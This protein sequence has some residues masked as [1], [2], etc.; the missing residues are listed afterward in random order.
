[1]TLGRDMWDVIVVGAGS[2]GAAVAAR[3]SED[4]STQVLVLEAGPDW[5]A[6]ELPVGLRKPYGQFAWLVTDVPA[7]YQWPDI[8]ARRTAER[9]AE[10]YLRGKGLGGTSVINGCITLRPPLA[11]FDD[12]AADGCAGWTGADVLP[13]FR[14]S[15]RDVDFGDS[16]VHGTD[17]P[18]PISRIPRD[19]WGTVD[20][21]LAE[22]AMAAGHRWVDDCNDADA[23]GVSPTASNILDGDRITT[24][25]A[26]LDPIRDRA[27]LTIVGDATVDRVL[28]GGDGAV[29]GVRVRV[30]GEWTEVAAAEVILSAG[31]IASPA[32]LQRSGIGPSALLR[33]L[34]LPVVADLPVGL[35]LQDHAGFE[36][37]FDVPGGRPAENGLRGNA[38][39]RFDSGHPD[40]GQG[41]LLITCLNS[42]GDGEEG[43]VLLK[44][45]QCFSLGEL[46][47]TSPDP[48][49]VPDVAE[50]L[51]G[52]GRDRD[53]TR[54]V[55]GHA[56]E[57]LG[58]AEGRG[59]V[60]RLR[61]IDGRPL[62]DVD[63]PAAVDAWARS[64]VR[65]TGHITSTARMGAESDPTT[66]VGTDGTVHGVPGL[67]VADASI[68]PTVARA[69]TNL[70]AIMIGERIAE[71]SRAAR[72]GVPA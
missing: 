68:M 5:R 27:N 4:P 24:N 30:A 3:V 21:L 17:G 71:F 35:G 37:L 55:F 40:A 33:E 72:V 26:Y 63:D 42:R 31:A 7:S 14:R 69:N 36:L 39:L 15:E 11:E 20:E 60:A 62:P 56:R 45:G 38:T 49:A 34:G 43:R 70:T 1:V 67:R 22:H 2:A 47:I 54:T 64:V 19:G 50:N 29:R 12:W 61:S 66:V 48:D 9:D 6:A 32:I 51:L 53:R 25:D 65:D 23:R 58:A 46:R 18:L 10:L 57:L 44:L 28:L 13:A 52:D 16:P 41:D 8:V 59:Q